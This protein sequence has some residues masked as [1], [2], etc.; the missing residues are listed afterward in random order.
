MIPG[1]T[2][3]SGARGEQ[4]GHAS[5]LIAGSRG[6]N[7]PRGHPICGFVLGGASSTCRYKTGRAGSLHSSSVSRSRRRWMQSECMIARTY[8]V[9]CPARL[10]TSQA[11]HPACAGSA[12]RLNAPAQRS[13]NR[14]RCM[15]HHAAR[16]FARPLSHRE[17]SKAP[18]ATPNSPNKSSCIAL[19]CPAQL[20][21][22]GPGRIFGLHLD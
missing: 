19:L 14:S 13:P 9:L 17:T 5:C 4:Q 15:L 8:L 7:I 12:E 1:A 16:R 20:V 22:V 3:G 10:I 21:L 2:G 6:C 11:P 18:Q